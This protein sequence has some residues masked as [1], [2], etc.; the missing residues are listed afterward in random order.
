M[1]YFS[2]KTDT[3][4]VCFS[5]VFLVITVVFTLGSNQFITSG[6]D[7]LSQKVFHREFDL[8]KWLPTISSLLVAPLFVLIVVNAIIFPKYHESSKILLIVALLVVMLGSIVY[9]VAMTT[10]AHVNSD[11]AA[12]YLLAK[13]CFL[14]KSILP[15][16][17]H[18]STEI[19]IVG[20]HLISAPMF[21]F[22]DNLT[23]I[24]TL[25]SLFCCLILFGSCWYVLSKL[26]IQKLWIKLLA[27]TM[28]ISPFSYLTWYVLQWGTFYIPHVVFTLLY[29]GLFLSLLKQSYGGMVKKTTIVL[30]FGLAF[31]SGLSTIR[32]ILNFQF[33]LALVMVIAKVLERKNDITN[34]KLFWLSDKRIFYSITGLFLGGLGYIANNLVL[35][36]LY[37]FAEWNTITFCQLGDVSLLDI[38]RATLQVLGFQENISVMTP[39]GIVN[40]LV[41][42]MVLIIVVSIF[43]L[44]KVNFSS[45]QKIFLQFFISSF[46]FNVFIYINTEFIY[47]YLV[48]IL[49]LL[50]PCIA[51][52]MSTD[53][54]SRN[55]KYAVGVLCAIVFFVS[56]FS[57]MQNRFAM[58]TNNDKVAVREFL[59]SQEYEFGYGTFWN[60]NVFNY[61]TNGEIEV[62]N[63]DSKTNEDDI[64][65]L[66][67]KYGYYN[68]LTPKRYYS[69]D[70]ENKPIFLI[71]S[72]AEYEI[73]KDNATLSVGKEVYSDQYY[74]VFEYPSHQ[75][76]KESFAGNEL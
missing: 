41:Y 60:A 61:L 55:M 39:L 10:D 18:Y 22:T 30:F 24:K 4:F 26:E 45:L 27:C 57:V 63:I 14:E 48:N 58:N 69:N 66:A 50:V 25:T 62:G 73:A 29:V 43:K 7:F 3:L 20:K 17:W 16:G 12:E 53:I 67:D 8:E 38:F 2:K 74:K 9:T 56:S 75:A 40:I 70:Y 5:I 15:L 34:I 47:R 76:F 51:I 28:I 33:P 72:Q 35:Q 11:L 44:L 19:Y 23:V 65:V 6:Y 1:N 71:L 36:R 59:V 21:L 32:Y 64:A 13:Q 42:V 37:S 52:I 31:F 68:W 54:L 49:V 46:L